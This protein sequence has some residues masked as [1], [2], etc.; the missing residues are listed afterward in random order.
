MTTKIDN[1]R[2]SLHRHLNM[3]DQG[4]SIHD[5][6]FGVCP[7]TSLS[8]GIEDRHFGLLV[9]CYTELERD[10]CNLAKQNA[11]LS[12]AYEDLRRDRDRLAKRLKVS[13]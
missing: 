12:E 11:L 2:Y 8:R 13:K 3:L 4:D 5:I 6:Y 7:K 1:L 10:V 9:E